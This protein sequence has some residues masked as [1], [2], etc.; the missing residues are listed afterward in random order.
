MIAFFEIFST[1][2][3][4]VI[5]SSGLRISDRFHDRITGQNSVLDVWRVSAGNRCEVSHSELR[6]NGFAWR[7]WTKICQACN[8]CNI[9]G[10]PAPLSPLTIIDWFVLSLS[11]WEIQ[12]KFLFAKRPMNDW[13]N[14]HLGV[15]IFGDGIYVRVELCRPL[16]LM[17]RLNSFLAIYFEVAERVDRDQNDTTPSVYCWLFQEPNPQVVKHCQ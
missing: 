7:Q 6:W 10:I 5:I 17:I 4:R 14:G 12:I 3:R 2:T 11:S 9:M 13:H 16:G 15:G 1:E 8:Q